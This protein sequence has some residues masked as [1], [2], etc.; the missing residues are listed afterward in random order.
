MPNGGQE[1]TPHRLHSL[2]F[3]VYGS[4]N[5]NAST[6]Q[7]KSN[8]SVRGDSLANPDREAYPVNP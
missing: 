6:L 7:P 5:P 1:A 3:V 2:R 8:S 4:V